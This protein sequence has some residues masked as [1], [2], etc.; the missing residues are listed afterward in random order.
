MESATR[1]GAVL[2][3][4]SVCALFGCGSVTRGG[5]GAFGQ[6]RQVPAAPIPQ[7]EPKLM[8]FGGTGHKVYLGC[9]NCS[10]YATDSVLNHFGNH[11]SQYAMDSVFN[12]YGDYGSPYSDTSACNP[13]ANDPPVIVDGNG[14]YYGRLT[15]NRYHLEI[16]TGTQF[17]GWL[18]SVCETQ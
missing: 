3:V 9:L 7:Y 6:A 1:L 11:G 18:A 5:P 12:R 15:L 2:L 4:V 8:I 17:L 10:E 14:K 13:Y 16:G